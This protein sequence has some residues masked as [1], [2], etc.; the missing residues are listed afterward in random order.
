MIELKL[1]VQIEGSSDSIV[2]VAKDDFIIGRSPTCDLSLAFSEVSRNH[3]HLFRTPEGKWL[4]EDLGSMNG[5]LLN[6][7]IITS[8]QKLSHLDLLQIGNV[9]IAVT[10]AD[11]LSILNSKETDSKNGRT[12][13][14]SAE[15][16]KDQWIKP[17]DPGNTYLNQETAIARLQ[18]LVE[19]A[20]GLNSAESIEDIFAIDNNSLRFTCC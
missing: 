4:L 11:S 10:F 19:I 3:A 18:H 1:R 2:S 8:A 5:T 6:Q 9:I 7:K 13:L 12:I 14:R 16:L 15:E 20:K 17:E